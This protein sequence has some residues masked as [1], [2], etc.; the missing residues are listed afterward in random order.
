[1]RNQLRT[2]VDGVVLNAETPILS[3]RLI[4]NGT[5]SHA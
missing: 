3:L 1:V 4:T 5:D 2:T